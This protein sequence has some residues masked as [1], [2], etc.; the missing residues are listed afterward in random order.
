M[1]KRSSS[2]RRFLRT[3][4]TLAATRP[5]LSAAPPNGS[6]QSA[7]KPEQLSDNLFLLRDTCN[8]YLIR[9]GDSALL[10]DFGSGRI[11][12]YLSDL[13]IQ[14]VEWILHTHHHRDQAQG[15]HLAQARNIPIAVPQ[16]ER[17]FFAEAENFW[18]NRRIYELYDVKNDF[19]TLTSDVP[20]SLLLRD[21]RTFQW[22]GLAFFVQPTP[23]HTPGS[24]SLVT[25]IDGRKVAF[26]GDLIHSSGKVQ[27]LY[28]LQY[29]YGEHEGVD[30]SIY[31]LNELARLQPQLLCPSHGEPMS[32]PVPAM[33]NLCGK[34]SDWHRYW[35][36]HPPTSEL[37]PVAVSP[38]L[39]ASTE[40]TS[41]FYAIVSDSGKAL[42]LDYGLASWTF[43]EVFRRYVDTF[44]RMR[45][46]E[47]SLESL[48]SRFGVKTFDV[49]MP[50]HMHDDHLSGFP[51]LAER[52][53]TKLWGYEGLAEIISHPRSRNLGCI[54]NEPIRLD[55]TF[56]DGET[57]RWE[58]FE[59]TVVHSPGHTDYQMAMFTTIDGTKVA[60]TG[61][62]F[63]SDS[64]N[65]GSIRHNLIY[66]NQVKSGDYL[67]SIENVLKFEPEMIAPG[68]GKP[69]RVTREMAEN[70]KAQI[71]L[72]NRFFRDLI[73]DRDTDMGIDPSWVRIAPYQ[74]AARAGEE[75]PISVHVRNH[76]SK[77]VRIT[78]QLVLPEGWKSSPGTIVLAADPKSE[79]SAGA[80]IAIPADWAIPSP[81]RVAISLDVM[82][83]R[84]YLGQITEAVIDVRGKRKS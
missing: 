43:F 58:E 81:P 3:T 66:R 45:F 48:R 20:V 38:H 82:A 18:R 69:F 75:T 17:Q 60:F 32:D 52:Y 77:P 4:G 79:A 2:R 67:R 63:F 46:L 24:V 22:R 47:H 8:V 27:T 13:N 78:A 33:K 57:F 41:S 49:A 23:G 37:E 44:G 39:I 28:D 54:F 50:S 9:Q 73:A 19:L 29:Y 35:Y 21:Y 11:L 40:T 65:P 36:K 76:R 30:L 10:V 26:S 83:D 80:V 71:E 1:G 5:L 70:F 25:E 14:R 51:Y 62:A 42:L 7:A 74:I 12:D 15:D 34:L 6:F 31:S 68:H 16:F 64:A 55:R 53:G 56:R 84:N 59:F 61:D 72:Q